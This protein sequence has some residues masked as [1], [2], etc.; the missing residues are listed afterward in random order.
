[1]FL[2]KI[3]HWAVR[4]VWTLHA[5][6][7]N[8]V[9]PNWSEVIGSRQNKRYTLVLSMIKEGICKQT[10]WS[11]P[12]L[13]K[14]K[15]S[16]FFLLVLTNTNVIYQINVI[17]KQFSF[18]LICPTILYVRSFWWLNCL[19]W[20]ILWNRYFFYQTSMLSVPLNISMPKYRI[21]TS[22][23]SFQQ[24]SQHFQNS[25]AIETWYFVYTQLILE[26]VT[27]LF[28]VNV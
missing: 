22:F 9:A 3:K 5:Y 18:C 19:F 14:I 26:I 7:L 17:H 27:R 11:E 28:D 25:V 21:N 1:M 24:Q 15:W 6:G 2:R 16:E 4:A 20:Y 23:W 10:K 12:K 13:N 8:K